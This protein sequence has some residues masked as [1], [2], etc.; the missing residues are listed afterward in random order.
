MVEQL[1]C[2][3]CGGLIIERCGLPWLYSCPRC[4]GKE[5]STGL[6]VQPRDAKYLN[7]SRRLLAS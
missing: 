3:Y 4:K 1:R 6:V 7:W 5:S 2:R